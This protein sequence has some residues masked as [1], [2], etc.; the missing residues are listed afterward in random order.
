MA[1]RRPTVRSRSA[2]RNHSVFFLESR[3]ETIRGS[4]RFKVQE[5][6]RPP[7]STV[8][9]RRCCA[10]LPLRASRSSGSSWRSTRD[11]ARP[12]PR[13]R[14]PFS[15]SQGRM[16]AAHPVRGH[17]RH[18]G[19]VADPLHPLPDPVP[20]VISEELRLGGLPLRELLEERP[21]SSGTC[22]VLPRLGLRV[23]IQSR[24]PPSS[25]SLTTLVVISDAL[26]P[27]SSDTR[28]ATAPDSPRPAISVAFATHLRASSIR[29]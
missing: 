20:P 17:L 25:R 6:N 27:I 2:P 14:A 15:T 21:N 11:R 26:I 4:N 29:S 19:R 3:F 22:S 24:L 10:P 12:R 7:S 28:A 23:G 1:F 16:Q 5:A 9:T 18:A 8:I 13:E